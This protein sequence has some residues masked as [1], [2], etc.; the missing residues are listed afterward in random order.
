APYQP[1]GSA[2]AAPAANSPAA[3]TEAR[4]LSFIASSLCELR[5]AAH[6]HSVPEPNGVAGARFRA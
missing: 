3:A 5:E 1:L 2:D 6:W 4:S